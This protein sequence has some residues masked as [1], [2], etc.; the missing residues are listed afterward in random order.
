MHR[1]NERYV[2][3]GGGGFLGRSLCSRLVGL[4]ASVTSITRR[5]YPELEALGVAVV[6]EDIS[7]YSQTF[8]DAF[9]GARCVFHTAAKVDM[10][11]K[12]L[13][14][15]NTNVLGTQNVIRAC[16]EAGVQFLIYTSSPSVIASGVDLCGVDESVPYPEKFHASYP[17]TKALAEQEVLKANDHGLFTLVLRPHLIY[18]PGDTHLEPMVVKRAKEGRLVRIGDGNNLVDF[19]YIED[20]VSAHLVAAE[21]IEVNPK[22]RGKIYFISQGVPV[23]LWDWIDTVLKRNNIAPVTRSVPRSLACLLGRIFE[24]LSEVLPFEPPFTRFLAEEMSTHHYFDISAARKDL[25]YEPAK[26]DLLIW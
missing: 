20:C 18:G 9:R 12:Y 26:K 1:S 8:R 22:C 14:F 25:L 19:S 16:K 13:D 10:W 21:A 5:H 6:Q 11:G 2:V 17:K 4:G 24:L 15:Y 3:T 23:K 7:V